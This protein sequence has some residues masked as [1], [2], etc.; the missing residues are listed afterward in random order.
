[1]DIKLIRSIYNT[2]WL[3][4]PQAGVRLLD[5][6]E[7]SI[8]GEIKWDERNVRSDSY[9]AKKFFE[10]NSVVFAPDNSYDAK[11]FKGFAG[12]T[13]AI[14][15]VCGPIMKHDFCGSYGTASLGRM[16]R[17][18]SATESIETI[19]LLIDSP[20]GSVDGTEAFA[21]I[22][23]ASSKK[24]IALCENLMASAG[25]WIGSSCNEMYASSNTDIIG[26]IGTMV[27]W[28]DS[29][30]AAEKAGYVL[31]EYYA[32]DSK[33]KNRAFIDANAGDGKKLVSELLDPLNDV[34]LT[35]VR[36]MRGSRLDESALT[37]KD[38]VAKNAQEV[39]LIDGVKTLEQVINEQSKTQSRNM[40]QNTMTAAEFRTANPTAYNE[41]LAIGAENERS[42]IQ[43]W[44]AWKDVDANAAEAGI[45]SGKEITQS[46]ISVF[47]AK[48]AN[49][50][51]LATAEKENQAPVVTDTNAPA[52]T[53]DEVA[54]E[55]AANAV[56]EAM[57]SRV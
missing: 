37:G 30:K 57:K 54:L 56:A 49:K 36:E 17:E 26:C 20:G 13:T 1:M 8:A 38:Y 31:R 16:V 14:I 24:T 39:G 10:G 40:S 47:S 22:I 45:A 18:A 44:N 11:D 7:K 33:D 21:N 52:K 3:I 51:A 34:F 53:A 35:H 29:S 15:P 12:A 41:I 28:M 48:A 46:D 50:A 6:W 5:L 4:Q 43:G 19:I 2:N 55:A 9:H 32:T 25:Y 42:R 23:K 27:S